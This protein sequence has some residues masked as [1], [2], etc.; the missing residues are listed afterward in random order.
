[1]KGSDKTANNKSQIQNITIHF[2][3]KSQNNL[4]QHH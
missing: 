1:M 4:N 3:L 2:L